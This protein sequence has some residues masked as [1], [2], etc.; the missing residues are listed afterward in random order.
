[1]YIQKLQKNFFFNKRIKADFL[2][3]VKTNVEVKMAKTP[4]MTTYA[5]AMTAYRNA[6][7]TKF[8]AEDT[9]R[10]TRRVSE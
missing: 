4:M 5:T 1:M 9:N 2:Q 7:A 8:P 6:V 3:P 10:R